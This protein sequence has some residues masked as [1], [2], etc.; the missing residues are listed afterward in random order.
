MDRESLPNDASPPNDRRSIPVWI[1]L[2]A[3]GALLFVLVSVVLLLALRFVPVTVEPETA[4]AS[5]TS[6]S[7]K[8]AIEEIAM[9]DGTILVLEAE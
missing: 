8:A 6:I 1:L 4:T 3:A 7:S 5:I 9:P 2:T